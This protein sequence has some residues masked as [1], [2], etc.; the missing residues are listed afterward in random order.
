MAVGVNAG[1]DQRATGDRIEDDGARGQRLAGHGH[2]AL[3]MAVQRRLA[4]ADDDQKRQ[5]G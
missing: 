3:H 5:D 1:I 4:T 2:D